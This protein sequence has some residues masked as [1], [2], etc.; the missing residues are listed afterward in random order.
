[1]RRLVTFVALF[2][3]LL[4]AAPILACVRGES[5]TQPESAC[6]QQM[7]GNCGEMAKMGCCTRKLATDASPQFRTAD[8]PVDPGVASIQLPAQPSDP[9]RPPS[10]ERLKAPEVHAPP[11]LLLVRITQLRI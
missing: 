7:H 4:T 11:G 9:I 1:M 3:L 8:F 6:C 2:L 10:L 5:M